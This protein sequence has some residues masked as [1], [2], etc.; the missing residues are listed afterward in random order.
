MEGYATVVEG[1]LTG[2][3]R[4]HG[5][6]R[7]SILRRWAQG[8]K[9]PSYARLASDSESWRGMSSPTASA[10]QFSMATSSAFWHGTRVLKATL[11]I[12]LSCGRSGRG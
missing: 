12:L 3:G 6:M 5:D 8:G 1:R 2:S 10:A 7:A 11:A 9:L 4:P